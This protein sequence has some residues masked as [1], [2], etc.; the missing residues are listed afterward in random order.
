MRGNNRMLSVAVAKLERQGLS[1][2]EALRAVMI[3][4]THSRFAKVEAG[5][6]L[7][8]AGDDQA[9][10][11]LLNVFFE[12]TEEIPLYETALA[13]ESLNDL[14]AVPQL[15]HALSEDDNPHRRRA[16]ARALGWLRWP[17][18][19]AALALA[20]CL[21]DPTQPLAA[22]EEAAESLSYVGTHETIE[23]LISVLGDPDVGIRFW[24]VFGLG[25][26][27]RGEARAV[28][29]LESVLNDNE[30]PSGNWWSVAKEALGMLGSM[31]PPVADYAARL[32]VETQRVF[33]DPNA[34]EADRRWAGTY[35]WE[36]SK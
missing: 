14:R 30:T 13:L 11:T 24:A 6:L 32:A 19:A 16:A 2:V 22:R 33:D 1:L 10:R 26:S 15:I 18:R 4:P 8:I 3:D 9:V 5:R 21:T 12:Q 31:H 34:T 35:W 25:G 28:R 23:P 17:G 36:D 7:S 29:A 20:R 27:C